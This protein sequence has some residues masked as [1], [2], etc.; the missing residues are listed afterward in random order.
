MFILSVSVSD[1]L[2]PLGMLLL[3][4]AIVAVL[5]LNDGPTGTYDTEAEEQ[6]DGVLW[7]L[8]AAVVAAIGIVLMKL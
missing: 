6:G 1:K 7:L 5:V 3:V 8:P 2:G 4:A